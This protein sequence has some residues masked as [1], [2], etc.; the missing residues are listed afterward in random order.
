MTLARWEP[1]ANPMSLRQAMDHLFEDAWVRSIPQGAGAGYAPMD[2]A[3]DQQG[4]TVK[5]AVPGIKPDDLEITVVGNVLTF[6]VD[7]RQ[8]QES[9]DSTYHVREIHSGGFERR[10]ELPTA[11]E[12]DSAS[13]SY[14]YG[15]V[16]LHLPKAATA[17]PRRIQISSPQ[18]ERELAGTTG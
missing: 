11:V 5:L 17:R 16:T 12:A 13:T 18:F 14:E 15:I 2:L 10:I 7:A 9:E 3:E 8:E 1:F 6:K 4:Y